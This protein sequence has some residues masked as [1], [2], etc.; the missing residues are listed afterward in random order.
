MPRG[1]GTYGSRRGRPSK[2]VVARAKPTRAKPTRAGGKPAGGKTVRGRI[3]A[4]RAGGGNAAGA[5]RGMRKS[6]QTRRRKA[7]VRPTAGPRSSR[8]RKTAPTRRRK[9]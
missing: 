9:R 3:A 5:I 2:K 7:A 1:L 6:N 4:L 8:T